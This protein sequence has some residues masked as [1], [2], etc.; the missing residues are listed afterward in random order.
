MIAKI[1]FFLGLLFLSLFAS[2][3]KAQIDE[4][5]RAIPYATKGETVILL[6]KL[7]NL[8]ISSVISNDKELIAKSL[9]GIIRCRKLLHMD[10]ATYQKELES[11]GY[12]S[13]IKPLQRVT[14]KKKTISNSKTESKKTK[15]IKRVVKSV[16]YKD[17]TIVIKFDKPLIGSDLDF[18]NKQSSNNYIVAYDIKAKAKRK[19]IYL[20]SLLDSVKVIQNRD[21]T[22][23]VILKDKNKFYSK[24]FIRGGN[25][26]IKINQQERRK[27]RDL[28]HKISPT[29][30]K[31]TTIVVKHKEK[32]SYKSSKKKLS[33]PKKVEISSSSDNPLYADSKLIV[34]DPGHG[35]KDSGAIGYK[36]HLEKK[37]VLKVAKLLKK[38]LVKKGYRV[39]MTREEDR[40]VPLKSRTHMATN[41]NA[42]LFI[43]IHANA[44]PKG[45][46]LSL[47]GLE[48]FFLSPA[49][50]A[51]A[52]RVAAK[53]NQ[54]ASA[55]DRR[56]KDTVL[57]FL[58]KTKII[59]SNKLAID[60]QSSLLKATRSK[61]RGVKDGGVREAPFW[62]LVGAQMPAVLV[63]IGYITNP[64]EGDRLYNPFYQKTLAKGIFNGI[65]NYFAKNR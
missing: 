43:S 20:K 47:K 12:K 58:N 42:D 62:V 14:V 60:I 10:Y 65:N 6:H 19:T 45:K 44:A 29:I 61:F 40:F 63:E 59:Q 1:A 49:R 48:T 38:M 56:S 13:K 37:A 34:I 52:K 51:R 16:G 39:K 17:D 41:L 8:Y 21:D 22:T 27:R 50:T 15:K 24:A 11:L 5:N 35:G 30:E 25:L 55:L 3:I 7:E 32:K 28:K 2:D 36:N 33:T 57:D 9:R 64:M 26:F 53:E 4:A 46:K 54:A 18:F 23:R 31:P